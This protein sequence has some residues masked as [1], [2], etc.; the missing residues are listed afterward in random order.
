MIENSRVLV[1]R[2]YVSNLLSCKNVHVHHRSIAEVMKFPS[3]LLALLVLTIV[4]TIFT[5]LVFVG[6]VAVFSEGSFSSRSCIFTAEAGLVGL[7]WCVVDWT[8]IRMGITTV[9]RTMNPSTAAATALGAVVVVA[10]HTAFAHVER[11]FDVVRCK[12]RWVLLDGGAL[13]CWMWMLRV[14]VF[15]WTVLGRRL[16]TKLGDRQVDYIDIVQHSSWQ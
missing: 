15:L 2:L 1:G 9:D 16:D 3:L 5:N 14:S 12:G 6:V 8:H 13:G 7:V 11:V 4:K 10:L